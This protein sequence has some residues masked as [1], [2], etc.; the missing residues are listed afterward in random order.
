MVSRMRRYY[1]KDKEEIELSFEPWD[2]YTPTAKLWHVGRIQK[3]D[4]GAAQI[5]MKYFNGFDAPY[6]LS[7]YRPN[8]HL[9]ITEAES[10]NM[11]YLFF[12]EKSLGDWIF[13][14]WSGMTP[15]IREWNGKELIISDTAIYDRKNEL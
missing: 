14:M 11:R 6:D 7:G 1:L 4:L 2:R 9:I 8:I 12:R 5:M 3:Y 13:K 10:L 15:Y